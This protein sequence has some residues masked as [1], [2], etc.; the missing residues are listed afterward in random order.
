MEF[1][2]GFGY[3]YC[4]IHVVAVI[5]FRNGFHVCLFEGYY[6]YRAP[7]RVDVSLPSGA[8]TK[9]VRFRWIQYRNSGYKND[10]WYIDNVVIGGRLRTIGDIHKKH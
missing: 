8:K 2:D 5:V 4:G 7:K 9:L 1:T 10:E 3:C 6:S